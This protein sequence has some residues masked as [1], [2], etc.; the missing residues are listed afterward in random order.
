M[1]N[2]RHPNLRGQ[3][4]ADLVRDPEDRAAHSAHADYLSEQPDPTL[5]ARGSSSPCLDLRHGRI[6]DAGART[7]A[8]CPE[9]RNLAW[10]DVA[11]NALSAER[12]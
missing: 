4:E 10:L 5:A 1:S 6:T 12:L 2:E 7:L 3:I 11:R 9:L 8:A